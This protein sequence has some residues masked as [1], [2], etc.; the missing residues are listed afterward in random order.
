MNKTDR[1]LAI[2]LELQRSKVLRAE[3]LASTFET[4]V[5]TIY[6][7]IQSLSEMGVP[8]L[9]APGQ[10]YS[11]MEGY[12]L[13]PVGFSV[14]EAVAMLMGTDFIEQR[15]DGDYAVVAKAARRKI[16]AILPEPVRG[17]STR[18]RE[19]M[20]LLQAGEPVTSLR[21]KDNLGL[22]RRAIMERRKLRMTYLKKMPET[23]GN[24]KS[25][26]EVAPY[27]LALVQGNWMLIAHCDLRQEIRHFRL[28]R[29]TGVTVMEDRFLIPNGFNLNNYRP[30]DDR[31]ERV[32]I[33]ANPQIADKITET[34]HFYMESTE[35]RKD[36]LI[37]NFLVRQPEELLSYILGWGGDVE[38]L[39]PETLR[40]RI[41]EEAEKMLKRY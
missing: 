10:G 25:T 22:A 1:Q 18:V 23:D 6:R 7:D 17:E 21:E 40:H 30:L 35:E 13:P 8:I 41:R 36:G 37:V 24:R 31:N 16:E 15:L 3:D 14:E 38:V 19:T 26:R 12:F 9:G 29:M 20:R 4:S 32:V 39:E 28:S 5:R 11:L 34:C 27:G 2:M 33:L